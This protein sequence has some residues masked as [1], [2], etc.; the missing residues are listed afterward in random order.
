MKP[1]WLRVGIR[2]DGRLDR[3][4]E[5]LGRH[6]L[7]TVCQ[8]ARCPNLPRCWG[9]GTATF[10]IL[11]DVCTRRCR[12]CSTRTGWPGGRV[13]PGEPRRIAAAVRELGLSYVVLTSVDRDDLPNGGAG[14]WARTIR[15]VREAAP[16]A[17]VEA[18]VPDFSGDREALGEVLAA[19]P[20]VLGH[21][22][23]TVRRLTPLVR[24][25]RAS[26]ELSLEV[27]AAAKR[28]RP[29]VLTKSSLLLG[30]GEGEEEVR[31][32]LRD[33]LSAGVDILV[34]GQY[35]RPGPEQL[36]VA[37]Y[38]PPAEFARWE[39]EAR[40]MGFRAVVAGPLVRT[41]F[42]AAEVYRGLLCG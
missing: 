17:V 41:S 37:R 27:L 9:A 20:R 22:L 39:E 42:R 13:D 23:E 34:L 36:P 38:L 10:M 15:A 5:V 18:L 7:H 4:V 1:E 21:N 6:R 26:Y 32:A 28:L 31:E 30:L 8:S 2:A 25:P 35:L 14:Q 33:L 19:G 40:R 16:G 11:G 12:F 24:D 3:M 29:G